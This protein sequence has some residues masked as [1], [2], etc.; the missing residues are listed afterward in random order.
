MWQR[1][2]HIMIKEFIQMFRDPRM[3]VVMFISPLFQIILMSFAVSTDV[4]KV[5]TAVYDLDNSAESR[6]LIQDFSFSK[7]FIIKDYIV[8]ESAQ[9]ELIDRSVVSTV[10][11]IPR[12]FSQ[13]LAAGRTASV[14]LILDGTDSNAASIILQY[15]NR[16]IQTFSLRIAQRRFGVLLSGVP[17][18]EL[19]RRAWFNENLESRNFYVPGVIGLVVLVVTFI[20]TAMTIVKE[21]ETGTIEQL[22]VSPI[23]PTELI[24][25]KLIPYG[26]VGIIDVFLITLLAVILFGVPIRGNLFLL[27]IAS[28]LFLLT[29]LGLGLFISTRSRTQQ[30]ALLSMFFFAQPMVLLSGF[31]FP[32]AAMPKVVQLLNM[33]NPLKY[34]LV[35]IRGIFLKGSG[36]AVLWPHM[37]ALLI[38]GTS[39]VS[40]SALQFKKKL[41]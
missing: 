25:G 13:D 23:R 19:R 9:R 35:I 28:I 27:F 7:Y 12:G 11:R 24:L 18:V 6:R 1:I 10:L 37:L 30:E 21:K 5:P 33:I 17:Q 4:K 31:V 36:I 38:I 40:L 26:A 34:F 20:L 29:T 32:V 16:I 39:I 3:K 15:A 22:I 14:Q 8:S 2:K 41:G